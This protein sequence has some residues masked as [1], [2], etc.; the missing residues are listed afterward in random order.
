LKNV[1]Q[2]G[3]EGNPKIRRVQN[4][5]G[6]GKQKY[7]LHKKDPRV[8]QPNQILEKAMLKKTG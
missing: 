6:I 7:T 3:N 1:Q 5:H 8:L 4:H 2:C